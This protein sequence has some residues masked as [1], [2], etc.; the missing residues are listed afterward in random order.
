MLLS[1]LVVYADGKISHIP[2]K[3]EFDVY[4]IHFNNDR[5]GFFANKKNDDFTRE[6]D[7]FTKAKDFVKTLNLEDKGF[8][9]LEEVFLKEL[10]RLRE[11]GNAIDSYKIYIPKGS[12][13]L[14][15]NKHATRMKNQEYYGSY[16]G[17]KF[18]QA[19]SV[20]TRPIESKKIKNKNEQLSDFISGATNFVVNIGMCFQKVK[21]TVPYTILT[22]LHGIFGDGIELHRDAY[23]QCVAEGD[24]TSRVILIQDKHNMNEYIY[25]P[26][27]ID[28]AQVF[29]VRIVGHDGHWWTDTS[30]DTV[31]YGEEAHT[32]YFY[33]SPRTNMKRGLRHYT[34]GDLSEPIT[35]KVGGMITTFENK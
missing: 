13:N 12:T 33:A 19:F 26:V 6:Q 23:I 3:D 34:S 10:D 28:E 22:G 27:L 9:G 7:N 32:E 21:V 29:S 5:K 8:K 18:K 14:S 17:Y 15:S 24:L 16:E 35:Q 20:T 30:S 11:D 4:E 1:C 25:V 31:A 2:S